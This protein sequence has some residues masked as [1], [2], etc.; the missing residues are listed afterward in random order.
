[1]N[2]ILIIKAV[3]HCTFTICLHIDYYNNIYH[4][5]PID[6]ITSHDRPD[7][8]VCQAIVSQTPNTAF[9]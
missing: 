3:E 8:S 1:M 6:S 9:H 4:I 2:R 5:L 7:V